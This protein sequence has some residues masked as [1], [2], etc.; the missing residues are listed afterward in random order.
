MCGVLSHQNF[1]RQVKSEMN[2][3]DIGSCLKKLR[4]SHGLTQVDLAAKLNIHRTTYTKYEN[5]SNAPEIDTLITIADFYGITLDELLG[6]APKAKE[7]I[8]LSAYERFEENIQSVLP[9]SDN[10]IKLIL[11]YRLCPDKREAVR[12]MR[13][14]TIPVDFADDDKK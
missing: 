4:T 9:L 3:T 12:Y 14:L 2:M 11:L 1:E 8:L 10:E 13:N 5:N 6:H 7:T